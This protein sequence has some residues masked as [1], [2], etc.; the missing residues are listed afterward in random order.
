MGKISVLI[1]DDNEDDRYLLNRDLQDTGLDFS[2]YEKVNGLEAINFF[3]DYRDNQ[4]EYPE[5]FPPMITFLDIN[6]PL[7][8]GHQFLREFSVIR[9]T[10]DVSSNIVMMF[11]SSE[12]SQDI[13]NALSYSFVKGYLVKGNCSPKELKE[14]IEEALG[15]K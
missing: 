6:M 13:D 9:E 12:R 1:I 14:K 5:D 3:K 2:I 8:D 7:L 15:G 4:S 11:T 10:I